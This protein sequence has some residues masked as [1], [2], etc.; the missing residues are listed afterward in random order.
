M[1]QHLPKKSQSFWLDFTSASNFPSLS[2]NI[3]VDVAIVGGGLVG[4]NAAKLLKQA[5][6]TVAILEAEEVAAGVSGHTTAK[7]TSLHQLIYADLIKQIGEQKA[8]LYG[9]SNQAAIEQY[10]RIIQSEQIDCDFERKD[11][12]TFASSIE[13]LDKI[14]D[15]LEAAVQLGLPASFVKETDLP[16]E[17]AG[18]VKFSNQAQFHPRKYVL[19][20]AK[21]I[22]GEGSYIFE[23]TRVKTVEGENP[24]KVITENGYI[25][26]AQDV[27]VATNLPIL[28]QGLF[29]AKSY[30]KRSYLIGAWIDPAQDPGG[31][32][33]G[34]GQDYQSI[35]TT[36]HDGKTLLIIGGK[37]HKVGEAEDTEILYKQLADYA[38][39]TFGVEEIAYRWSTQD[40]VSFD[41]L[42]YIGKLTPFNNHT[43]VATGFSLWGMSKSMISAMILSDL[44]LGKENPWA[45]LYDATRPTPFVTQES[46]KQN[47][48]VGIHWVGDRLKG[49]LD[50][51]EKVGIG[52][53]QVVTENGD[54]IAAYRDESGTLHKVSAVCTHLGCIVSW[55]PAEK[56]WDCPCHGARYNCEGEVIQAPAVSDLKKY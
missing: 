33:I 41:K 13:N 48:D 46:I 49:L 18:S 3:S 25:V 6:K 34:S 14:K 24:C 17:I 10:A 4:I 5:G 20:L 21:T 44:I 40:M 51:P 11:A 56:S 19:H 52:E 50:S 45:N 1:I 27:I 38:N 31:M 53:G 23:Q 35:R 30:P 36:P 43:Y 7:I 26:T 2:Q 54:K 8:R 9:E 47:L 39:S 16:F 37:G 29:F 32:F 28:D 55:N 22:Q 12:Y 42:P 15:E